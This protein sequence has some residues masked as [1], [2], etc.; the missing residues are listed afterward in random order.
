[1]GPSDIVFVMV[2]ATDARSQPISHLLPVFEALMHS[3]LR[4]NLMGSNI[5]HSMWRCK[6]NRAYVRKPTRRFSTS[7]TAR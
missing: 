1:M 6:Y 3:G 7:A 4:V 5:T 2:H